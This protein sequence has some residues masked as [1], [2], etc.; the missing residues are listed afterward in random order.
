MV[1]GLD[2]RWLEALDEIIAQRSF[3]KA[4]EVLCVSQSAISQ[5]IKQLEKW[6]AQPVLVRE[7]PPRVTPAGQKLL[8]LYRQVCILEQDI[9]PELNSDTDEKAISVSIATN[10]DSLATWLLPAIGPLMKQH[11]LEIHLVVDHEVRT[12]D[13]L[14][15]GEVI[16]AISLSSKPL[17]GCNALLLGDMPYLCVSTPEFYQRYFLQGVTLE[18]L[19]KAPAISFDR[20][21]FVN[22]SFALA[23]FDYEMVSEVKHTVGSSEACVKAALAG[24]GYCMIPRIQIKKELEQGAL[25]DITP[26][27]YLE[28]QLYWHHWQLESGILKKV[29]Q[30]IVDH[31]KQ[32]LPQRT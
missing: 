9:L 15:N 13:K 12:I 8:G 1:R 4:A 16:G 19:Q 21:D 24:F 25:I 17:P 26:G 30:A 27:Y 3:E 2:Y 28:Q 5:R 29:S 32:T 7:Q 10:A 31:A 20:H 22:E 6:L 18:T 11:K 14:K 23:A